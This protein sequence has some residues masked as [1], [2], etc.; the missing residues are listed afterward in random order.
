MGI[1]PPFYTRSRD[2]FSCQASDI[3]PQASTICIEYLSARP[4]KHQLI[5]IVYEIQ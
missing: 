2:L 1:Y 3:I 5:T 4:K